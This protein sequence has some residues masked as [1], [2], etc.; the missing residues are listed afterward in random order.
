MKKIPVC[1]FTSNGQ[2]RAS[3]LDEL[4]TLKQEELSCET[5]IFDT[6]DENENKISVIFFVL[7]S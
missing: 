4:W 6:N 5:V 3:P 1:H 2:E 7:L